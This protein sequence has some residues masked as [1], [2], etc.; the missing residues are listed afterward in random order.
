[1]QLVKTLLTERLL[2][3]AGLLQETKEPMRVPV[4]CLRIEG[5]VRLVSSLAIGIRAKKGTR[6]R[7]VF[8]YKRTLLAKHLPSFARKFRHAMSI[9]YILMSTPSSDY[10]PH[11]LLPDLRALKVEDKRQL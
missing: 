11:L 7:D 3:I 9:Y 6:C 8:K 1:M 2:S 5:F 4:A 10:T